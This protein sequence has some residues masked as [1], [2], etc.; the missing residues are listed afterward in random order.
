MSEVPCCYIAE[1]GVVGL[2]ALDCPNHNP[3]ECPSCEGAPLLLKGPEE[4][5]TP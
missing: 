1:A 3:R 4:G 5:P 2:H